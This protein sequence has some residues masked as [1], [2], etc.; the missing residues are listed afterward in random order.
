MKD[1]TLITVWYTNLLGK[2]F[3]PAFRYR[4]EDL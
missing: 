3:I 4:P 1:G 2:F